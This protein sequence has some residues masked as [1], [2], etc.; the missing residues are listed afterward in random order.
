MLIFQDSSTVGTWRWYGCQPFAL[1]AFISVLIHVRG[2]GDP[3]AIVRPEGLCQWKVPVTPSGVQP[4]TFR[5]VAQCLNQ[6]RHRVPHDNCGNSSNS[7]NYGNRG[8]VSNCFANTPTIKGCD[9]HFSC[10]MLRVRPQ[11]YRAPLTRTFAPSVCT[12][13]QIFINIFVGKP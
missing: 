8:D 11:H 5:L 10:C 2:W 12:R 3:R 13:E 7:G 6:M 1:T 9:T 4:M